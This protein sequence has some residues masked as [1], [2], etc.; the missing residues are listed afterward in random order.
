[1]PPRLPKRPLASLARTIR[2]RLGGLPPRGVLAAVSG[3]ADSSALALALHAG[4]WLGGIAH[5]D[6]GLR[7]PDSAADA[8][9]TADLARE[10]DVPFLAETVDVAAL[11]RPRESIEMAARRIRRDFLLRAARSLSLQVLATGHTADDQ[12]ETVLLRILKGTSV[13]GLAGIAYASDLPGGLRLVRPLLD[14]RRADIERWLRTYGRTWRTDASNADRFALRNRIRLDVL[15]L[16]RSAVNPRA[17]EALIRLADIARHHASPVGQQRRLAA[18]TLLAARQRP[19][20]AHID[21]LAA[22]AP[23]TSP[24]IPAPSVPWL[25]PDGRPL[26]AID[27]ATTPLPAILWA[28]SD[29]LVIAEDATGWTPGD[30]CAYLARAP[31]EG[32]RLA[33]RRPRPGDRLPIASGTQKLSDLFT[34]QKL[35]RAQRAQTLLVTLDDAP[36]ALP[37]LRLAAALQVPQ[38]APSIRLSLKKFDASNIV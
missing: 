13:D 30:H 6:H 8:R 34:N 15:P 17:D 1:M 37:P 9:W 14:T 23:A 16:L 33:L 29:A 22:T 24:D 4:G 2:T 21:R 5:L 10:L 25:L 36:V 35:P 19:D 12:A 27:I 32:H 38:N 31:L 11:R 18:Q 28:S 3:G 26:P 20:L 7:G